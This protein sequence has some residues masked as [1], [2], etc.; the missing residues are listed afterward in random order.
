MQVNKVLQE[1]PAGREGRRHK[2][3]QRLGVVRRDVLVGERRA[4]RARMRGFDDVPAA[5]DA[6][7]LLFHSLAAALQDLRLAAVDESGKSS[8]ELTV[9]TGLG[10]APLLQRLEASCPLRGSPRKRARRK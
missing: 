9:D 4:E 3:D 10:H 6:Q 5:R 8:F 7:R 1:L 2:L